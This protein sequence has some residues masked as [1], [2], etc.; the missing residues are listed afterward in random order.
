VSSIKEYLQRSLRRIGLYQRLRASPLYD[1]Y[2]RIAD[3]KIIDRRNSEVQF[4][5]HLLEGFHKGDLVFDIGAN[6]GQKTDVFLRLGATVVAIEPDAFNCEVLRQKFQLYRLVKKPVTVVG[7]A[8][9]AQTRKETMW[10][11]EPGSAKNSL[12]KKWVDTLRADQE[13]FGARLDFKKRTEVETV[14]LEDLILQHGLPFFVKIDV[15]GYEPNVL[16]G[17][18]RPVRYLSFEVNLPEFRPEGL[19]CVELLNTLDPNGRFNYFVDCQK[20]LALNGWLTYKEFYP[21]LAQCNEC[22]VEVFWSSDGRDQRR[23]PTSF[24]RTRR[25]L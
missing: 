23:L 20:G 2:W 25:S 24:E 6:Q 18:R 12:S 17:L 22:S 7:K 10:I 21:V 13:R 9:G 11:D 19:E 14:P 5:R 15:E 16:R 1:F 8:V 3:R 4:Y